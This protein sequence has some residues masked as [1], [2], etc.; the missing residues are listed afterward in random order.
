MKSGLEEQPEPKLEGW[1]KVYCKHHAITH[2]PCTD[3]LQ[4]ATEWDPSVPEQPEQKYFCLALGWDSNGEQQ[5][6]R[7][8][9]TCLSHIR[10]PVPYKCEG[11]ERKREIYFFFF[12]FTVINQVF[13]TDRDFTEDRKNQTLIVYYVWA[14]LYSRW[15]RRRKAVLF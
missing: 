1:N 10:L 4:R 7:A 2:V 5:R 6:Y 11:Q 8:A 9:A 3:R 15:I 14:A 12:F 13:F